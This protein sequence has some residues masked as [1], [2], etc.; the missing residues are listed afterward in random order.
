MK[1]CLGSANYTYTGSGT[2]IKSI[3][4]AAGNTLKE[5]GDGKSS[6]WMFG[7]AVKGGTETLPKTTLDNTYLKD[8]DTL[9]LF[10]TDTYIPLDPTDPTVPGT[11]VPGFDEAYAG[12]KAYIQSAVSAPVVSYLFGEWAVLGQAR[13]GVELSDAYIQAYYDKVVA[14]VRKNMGA[15]GVLR[16]P[17]SHNPAITDNERIALALTAIGKDPANVSGKN[18]LAALQ[19]KDIMKVTD[20]SYTDI[21]GLVM[22]LLAL[23]SRNYTSDTSW[24][25]QAIL[26][27]QLSLIHI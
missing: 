25:V 26:G 10:F 3:T 21:N 22:G 20:T 4:D 12:A 5:K 18:L 24:L 17:E 13:A 14:Y 2:Y 7:L 6:G 15:D 23:N 9:R 27:Q 8:G 16:D 11:E 1:A 19:D